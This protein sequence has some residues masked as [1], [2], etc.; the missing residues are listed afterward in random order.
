MAKGKNGKK[1]TPTM[2]KFSYTRKN[3]RVKQGPT[4]IVEAEADLLVRS[5][6][7]TTPFYCRTLQDGKLFLFGHLEGNNLNLYSFHQYE[8][9]LLPTKLFVEFKQMVGDIPL[10][11]PEAKKKERTFDDYKR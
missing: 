2:S 8:S 11:R 6:S 3:W 5:A 1:E 9:H 7:P 10:E 4:V